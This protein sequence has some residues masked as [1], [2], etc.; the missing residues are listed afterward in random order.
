MSFFLELLLATSTLYAMIA[1]SHQIISTHGDLR[2]MLKINNNGD[3]RYLVEQKKI[4][5]WNVGT[6][7]HENHVPYN[8]SCK[9]KVYEFE[10]QVEAIEMV[11]KIMYNQR[12]LK[13]KILKIDEY[14]KKEYIKFG[15]DKILL[16]QQEE[17]KE[18]QSS[19]QEVEKLCAGERNGES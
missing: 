11:R 10:T 5:H 12:A 13:W 16:N 6:C 8:C 14:S 15:Y 9:I 19:Y 3:T 1:L 2:I 4:L 7:G 17:L 18:L